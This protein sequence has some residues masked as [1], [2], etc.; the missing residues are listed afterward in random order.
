MGWTSYAQLLLALVSPTPEDWIIYL[1][2]FCKEGFSDRKRISN[3]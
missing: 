3:S 1:L 2:E